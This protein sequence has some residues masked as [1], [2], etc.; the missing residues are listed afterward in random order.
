[1]PDIN[2]FDEPLRRTK[3]TLDDLSKR[4]DTIAARLK[5]FDGTS[6]QAL[7]SNLKACHA[8]IADLRS[9]IAGT[10]DEIGSNQT[11]LDR[12]ASGIKSPLNPRNWFA[13]DQRQLRQTKSEISRRIAE[14]QGAQK[15]LEGSLSVAETKCNEASIALK[16]Y[17]DF[18]AEEHRTALQELE[19][20]IASQLSRGK[21]LLMRKKE[22]DAALQPVIAQMRQYAEQ[23]QQWTQRRDRAA[24]LDRNLNNASNAYERALVHEECERIFQVGSPRKVIVECEKQLRRIKRDYDKAQRRA[25]EIGAKAARRIDSIVIDGNNLC[26]DNGTFI[27][28]AALDSLVPLLLQDYTVTIVFDS[29]IRRMLRVD[30]RAL[31]ARFGGRARVHVVATGAKADETLL[32]IASG[33]QYSYVLS[34]DRFGEFNDKQVVKQRR[35]IRHEIFDQRILVH[36]LGIDATFQLSR[37]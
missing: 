7:S 16:T 2:P 9:K 23:S 35:L 30:D 4:K 31:A 22:V 24:S 15:S 14:L 34:N 32:D 18:N 5:W 26:Y 25:A 17:N 20:Q 19:T 6:E 28:T 27:G 29:A 37:Q 3:A 11:M 21:L 1:M 33:E 8:T 12:T 13:A 10:I 36:D